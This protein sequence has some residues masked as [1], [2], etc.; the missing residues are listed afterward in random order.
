MMLAELADGG[1][2]AFRQGGAGPGSFF[3]DGVSR[4]DDGARGLS[5]R[6]G[7]AE[8]ESGEAAQVAFFFQEEGPGL[9]GEIALEAFRSDAV[10][11]G[12]EQDEH[13]LPFRRGQVFAAH[14]A[15]GHSVYSIHRRPASTWG[16]RRS[17][18][19]ISSPS[20]Q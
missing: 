20:P 1:D 10:E 11:V 8:E 4:V 15:A 6:R 19:G 13:R 18:R 2:P 16:R 5:G 14:Q 3:D 7:L 12:L 17:S 9:V